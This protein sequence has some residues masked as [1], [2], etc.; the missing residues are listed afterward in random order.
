MS[1]RP[2]YC[3]IVLEGKVNILA[4]CVSNQRLPTR[5]NLDRRGIDLHSTRCPVCDDDIETEEHLFATCPA[6]I[7]SWKMPVLL[8]LDGTSY[9]HFK[10]ATG[11]QI[12]VKNIHFDRQNF[13]NG[14]NFPPSAREPNC[15]AVSSS[16]LPRG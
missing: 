15:A 4:W 10:N 11:G 16:S 8:L 2:G 12:T 13:N 6:A 7:D 5:Y 1:F 3:F 14:E 9:V